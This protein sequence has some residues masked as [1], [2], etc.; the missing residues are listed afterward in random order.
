M[1]VQFLSETLPWHLKYNGFVGTLPAI[2]AVKLQLTGASIRFSE[3]LIGWSC[4]YRS[5]AAAPMLYRLVLER[6]RGVAE[7]SPEA[8]RPA[9]P[10]VGGEFCNVVG[11]RY[12]GSGSLAQQNTTARFT[13]TLI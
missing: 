1:R 11:M 8:G 9:V 4:L 7:V 10:L 5:T 2:E 3:A 6:G 12:E 13:I